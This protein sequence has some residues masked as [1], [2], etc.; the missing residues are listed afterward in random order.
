[1]NNLFY[2]IYVDDHAA[3]YAKLIRNATH[4]N[5]NSEQVCRLERIYILQDFIPLKIGHQ[6][7]SFLEEKAKEQDFD[8]MWLTVYVKNERAIRFYQRNDY[9]EIGKA[10][11]LV[12]EQEYENL[13][14]SKLL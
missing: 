7:L 13:V 8:T 12:N 11:F 14:L 10:M 9:K 2:I 6:F 1:M 5:I 3:G 4:N